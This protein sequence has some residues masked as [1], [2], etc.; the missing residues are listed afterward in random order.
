[1]SEQKVKTGL[2]GSYAYCWD[3]EQNIFRSVPIKT[4]VIIYK[5][6]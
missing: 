6:K 4:P 3:S 2:F 5:N 1:M